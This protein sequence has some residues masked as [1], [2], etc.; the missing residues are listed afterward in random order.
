MG[1]VWTLNANAAETPAAETSPAAVAPVDADAGEPQPPELLPWGEKPRPIKLAKA[2]SSSAEVA[3]AGAGAAPVA[4]SGST[5]RRSEYGLKGF[6][7]GKR[8]MEKR[9]TT[10]VPP[11][12]PGPA[13][14]AAPTKERTVVF[15]YAEAS[16]L[17]ET[18]GT[19]AN[20]TIE[21]PVLAKG[22]YHTLA[23]LAVRSA[24]MQQ[25]VEVGWTVDRSVNGDNDPHLFVYHWVDGV[26]T[27]YNKCGFKLRLRPDPDNPKVMVPGVEPGAIMPLESQKRFGIVHENGGW[28]IAYDSDYIGHFPDSNWQGRFTKAGYT[29]WFGEVASPTE[30]PCS[31]MGSGLPVS[32][33]AAARIGTIAMNNG[34]AVEFEPVQSSPYY[35]IR[36][37]KD[38]DATF[39]YG[40][41]GAPKATEAQPDN[42]C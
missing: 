41:P 29:Q 19:W 21:D 31:E 7:P 36:K 12:P 32:K 27:C 5:V 30:V 13:V 16:Q 25:I 23:E 37:L 34:P 8:G 39:R 4:K 2:G 6:R 9:K 17:G 28:W 26:K 24:D 14:A 33:G 18:E 20:L 35:G 38:A 15:H 22:E 11:A 10:I 1:V 42:P 3:A 40:G